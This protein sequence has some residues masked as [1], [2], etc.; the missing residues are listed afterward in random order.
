VFGDYVPPGTRIIAHE[1][2]EA[3][4]EKNKQRAQREIE[5]LRAAGLKDVTF[6]AAGSDAPRQ[7]PVTEP[8]RLMYSSVDVEISGPVPRSGE[9]SP[10]IRR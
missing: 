3:T 10:P 1:F 8:M 4:P 2:R 9:G 5:R 7:E 6:V